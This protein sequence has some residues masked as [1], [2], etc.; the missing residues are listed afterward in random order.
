MTMSRHTLH[1]MRPFLQLG[2]RTQLLLSL[3]ESLGRLG[4]DYVNIP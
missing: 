2:S 1:R 4:I 3:G